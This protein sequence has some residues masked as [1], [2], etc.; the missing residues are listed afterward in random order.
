MKKQ[1]FT[2][3]LTEWESLK[4]AL[5]LKRI[6]FDGVREC[7]VDKD[8]TYEIIGVIEKAMAQLAAQGMAPR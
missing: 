3:S 1:Q 2:I 8:E 7:S 4:I 5:F 6:I